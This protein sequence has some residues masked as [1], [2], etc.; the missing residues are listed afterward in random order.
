MLRILPGC[1]Q[2]KGRYNHFSSISTLFF[3]GGII[4]KLSPKLQPKSRLG[5]VPQHEARKLEVAQ[6]PLE[7]LTI[8]G[9]V[10]PIPMHLKA[11]DVLSSLYLKP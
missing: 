9:S 6:R 8:A 7:P 4:V 1:F 11:R 10:L 2:Y 3:Y 5:H